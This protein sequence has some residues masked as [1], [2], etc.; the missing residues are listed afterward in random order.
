[1]CNYTKEYLGP[2]GQ[3]TKLKKAVGVEALE[4]AE[5]VSSVHR[6]ICCSYNIISMA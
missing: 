5:R 3:W 1:M 2:R 4:L 6:I